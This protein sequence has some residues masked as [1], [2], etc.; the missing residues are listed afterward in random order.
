MSH[1]S[2]LAALAGMQGEQETFV[3]SGERYPYLRWRSGSVDARNMVK[4]LKGKDI[5]DDLYLALN[6]YWFIGEEDVPATEEGGQIDMVGF[7]PFTYTNVNN[8]EVSGFAAPAIT[9]SIFGMRQAWFAEDGRSYMSWNEG[10]DND[11]YNKGYTRKRLQARVLLEGIPDHEFII[12]VQGAKQYDFLGGK[13]HNG[14]VFEAEKVYLPQI[15]KEL[16]LKQAPPLLAVKMT[17]GPK[18]DEQGQV[19]FT[20][21]SYEEEGVEKQGLATT[22]FAIVEPHTVKDM[23]AAADE[24]GNMVAYRNESQEWL[25]EWKTSKLASALPSKKTEEAEPQAEGI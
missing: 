1:E 15:A 7:T 2:I 11:A 18:C 16:G 21:T 4:M 14:V 17:V 12:D 6:G 3:G 10:W 23:I 13:K 20:S 9:F 5:P 22:T 8:K 19:I 24:I 25:D